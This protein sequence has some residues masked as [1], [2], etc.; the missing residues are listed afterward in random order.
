[1]Q[2]SEEYLVEKMLPIKL[3]STWSNDL[4]KLGTYMREL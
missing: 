1:M 2:L 4:K 3:A